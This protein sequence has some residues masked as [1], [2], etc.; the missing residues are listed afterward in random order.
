MKKYLMSG[1]AAIAFLA[2]FT[3]CSKSTDLY[4]Q[5]AV[6]ER[7]KQEQQKQEEKKVLSYNE[8]F[9]NEFGKVDP[10]QNWG[11]KDQGT[12]AGTRSHNVNVNEWGSGSGNGG[13]I[14]V[15]NNVTTTE[16]DLVLAKFSE[17]REGATNTVNINW[18]DFYVAQVHKGTETYYDWNQYEWTY[19]KG[20]DPVRGELKSNAQKNVLGS[21][22][23]NH[24]QCF[25]NCT[26][27]DLTTNQD[28]N[29]TMNVGNG[30]M[31]HINNFNNGNNTNSVDNPRA[32]GGK[33]I[34]QTFMEN[35]GTLDFAYHNTADSKYHNEYIIIAGADIDPSLAGYYY[36]GFDF[37]A[38]GFYVQD[39]SGAPQHLDQCVDRDW[40]FNDWIVRISPGQFVGQQRVFV[41]DLITNED[42]N[43]I[44]PSDWDFNDAVFDAY[45]SNGQAIITLLAAGGTLD[46]TVG[47]KEVHQ[48]FGVSQETMVNTGSGPDRA[49]VMF[50]IA[51]SSTNAKDIPVIVTT[52]KGE[53]ITLTANQGDP[54]QKIAADMED[55]VKWMKERTHIKNGYPKFMDYVGDHTVKWWD[56]AIEE[57]LYQKWY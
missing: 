25:A 52:K 38:N 46:L 56:P 49:P 20:T 13:H 19:A 21:D 54:T 10:N 4:D 51:C 36:V 55:H 17:K 11:F 22:K 45:I 30:Y 8:A 47:G 29:G 9:E 3:S 31:E 34:G 53:K 26:F 57:F 23:M 50:H 6:D 33:I 37:C 12:N 41:E 16:H 7:N 43:K 1:V 32:T 14:A 27:A 18:T 40:V 39:D 35:S 28:N 2:A 5:G 15:P 48:A 24:L 42:L 44:D